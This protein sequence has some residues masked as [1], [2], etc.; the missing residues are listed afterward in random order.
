VKNNLQV[1]MSLLNSQANSLT[2]KVALSAIQESQHRVQAVALIHQKLY[3]NEG[4]SRIPMKEYI[5][6][7]VTYLEHFYD[8]PQP[9]HFQLAIDPI[10]LD[11]TQAIPLGL[12]IN[13]ALTNALKYAFRDGRSGAICL[14][15][16]RLER[17]QLELAIQDDGVGLPADYNPSQSGSLGMTLMLGLSEQL[18]G[19]L[20]VNSHPGLT[21]TLTFSGGLQHATLT[22]TSYG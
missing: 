13:E 14:S 9:V 7:V 4:V 8:L 15:L 21:I 17:R 3:Q 18:G 11:V 6:E 20:Q 19:A 22:E 5:E 2:D 16:R 12:I 1:I 10:E